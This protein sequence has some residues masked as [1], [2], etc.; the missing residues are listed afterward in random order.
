MKPKRFNRIEALSNTKKL[1]LLQKIQHTFS[2]KELSN[3]IAFFLKY[4]FYVSD[5][6]LIEDLKLKKIVGYIFKDSLLNI[7]HYNSSINSSP[8]VLD[9]LVTLNGKLSNNTNKV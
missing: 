9:M 1:K 3:Y 7:I 5:I 8:K 2:D 4:P 6:T